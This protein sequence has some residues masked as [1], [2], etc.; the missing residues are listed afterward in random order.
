MSKV[1]REKVDLHQK[2]QERIAIR[3]SGI[4]IS[5]FSICA[6]IGIFLLYSNL[7][8]HDSFVSSSKIIQLKTDLG[9]AVLVS[10]VG[11][12]AA[13]RLWYIPDIRVGKKEN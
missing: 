9:M 2:E 10:F 12:F 7:I 3:N 4:R 8:H 1:D 13:T 11:S 5:L 6:I